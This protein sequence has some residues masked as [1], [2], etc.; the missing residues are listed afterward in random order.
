MFRKWLIFL[1]LCA[2]ALPGAVQAQTVT[3]LKNQAPNGVQLAF[4]MTDGTVLGQSYSDPQWY[5]LTPDNTGSYVNG[6]WKQVASFPTGYSADAYSSAVL[7]DG[8][9]L[10]EGGEYNFGEFALTNLGAIY[11]PTK[12]TWTSVTP[13]KGWN[14]IGDSPAL[15]LPNGDFIIGNKLKKWAAELDP[16][17]MTWTSL[18]TAGKNDF[19]AEEGWTLMPDGSILTYD[20]KDNPNSERYVVDK[21]KWLNAGSTV[22]NL[23]GP[24]CCGC[25]NYGPKNKC[26]Y[27]PGET[28]PGILMPNGTVFA[29]GATHTGQTTAH[30]AIY[31]PKSKGNPNGSWAAG[32]DFPNEDQAGD[33]FAALLPNGHALVEGNS[34]TLYEFDGTKLTAEPVNAEGN[35]LL[36]LPTGQI[37]VGGTEVYS[38]A[39]NPNPSWAPTITNCPTSVTRGSTYQISGTQFNGLSQANSFGDEYQTAT[40]YPLVQITNTG[41]GH[42]FYARTHDHSTMGVA[43]GSTP[44]STN[45]DVPTTMETGASTLVVIANGIASTPFSITVN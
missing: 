28:G 21:G 41:T 1:A 33:D 18:T 3:K 11:D 17:T 25:I 38:S 19:N 16:K 13:P 45:F 12:N 7:A 6:T 34:G 14:F 5:V 23:Q 2:F 4:L 36:V 31:T 15:V 40:N 37:L 30:T 44:V 9:L 10:V 32:P 8:R 35:S 24:P 39:G 27:P 42:V 43:T 29:T 26:Y 22:A 20:V